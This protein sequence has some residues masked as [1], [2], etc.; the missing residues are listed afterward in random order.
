[1]MIYKYNVLFGPACCAKCVLKYEL[2]REKQ[3]HKMLRY[4]ILYDCSK[5]CYLYY[6]NIILF[7]LITVVQNCENIFSN[8]AI[9]LY[10]F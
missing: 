4:V 6:K 9:L 7:V 1:M 3:I 2:G 8:L 5:C 10:M